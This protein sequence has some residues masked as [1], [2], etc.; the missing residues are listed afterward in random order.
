V[1]A[2]AQVG[3]RTEGKVAIAW[4]GHVERAPGS[5]LHLEDVVVARDHPQLLDGIPVQRGLVAQPAIGLP[6]VDVKLRVEHI[7]HDTGIPA[8]PRLC[9]AHADILERVTVAAA[10]QACQVPD[11]GRAP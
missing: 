6:R 3:P 9:R 8:A 4:P 11:H 1:R 7:D 2:Q 10:G 5:L